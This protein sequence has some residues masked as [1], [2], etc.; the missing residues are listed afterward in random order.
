MAK[1]ADKKIFGVA[2][3]DDV[4]AQVRGAAKALDMTYSGFVEE[5]IK[6][7][8]KAKKA[9]TGKRFKKI[10]AKVYATPAKAA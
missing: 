7:F 3:T 1:T 8:I 9:E 10:P 5:A 2:L 6:A 4:T